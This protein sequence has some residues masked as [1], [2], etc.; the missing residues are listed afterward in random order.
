MKY[1]KDVDFKNKRVL[2]RADFNV[3]LENGQILD[4]FR[5]RQSLPTIEYILKQDKSK[6]VIISHLGR[7]EGKVDPQ[8]SL[9]PVAK[10]LEELLKKKVVFIKDILSKE[11]DEA[12]QSLEGGQIA[13]AENLRFWPGEEANDEKF[14]LDVCH[15][16]GVYVNDAFSDSHRAHASISQISR[17]KP[18][19]AGLLMEKEIGELSKALKPSKRPAI[20]IIGGA[21]IETK[22]PVIENLAESYD[23]VLIGG[24][25][26][27][28]AQTQNLKFSEN[29]ILPEDYV[30]ENLD[31]GPKTAEKYKMAASSASFLVWNGPMGKF[32]D[33]KYEQGTKTILDAFCE[34]DA[35]KIAGG[36]ETLE[37]IDKEKAADKFNFLSSGGG[38]MLEFLE[39][40][41]LPGIDAL[42]NN[43]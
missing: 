25:I 38:A 30:D 1:L 31:I 21:K 37:F 22:M 19:C 8:Y 24:K 28:E 16:F 14:A 34:A 33:E 32:E 5:I 41:K 23:A 12:I 27:V 17:F 11:G 6:I 35:W 26:A 29:V 43:S 36:G 3:P 13:L 42:E 9:E 7:P 18:S 2:L 4:D 39:G 10:K 40:K 15:H 20:A